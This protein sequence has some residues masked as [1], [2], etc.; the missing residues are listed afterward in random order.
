MTTPAGISFK[1]NSE[2]ESLANILYPVG[3]V[4]ISA[5]S[6]I[7]PASS[8]G[9]QWTRIT[10]AYLRGVANNS[11]NKRGGTNS[12][13][14]KYGV[15]WASYYGS[16]PA[17]DQNPTEC[18]LGLWDD[19]AGIWS[20]GQTHSLEALSGFVNT[21]LNTEARVRANCTHKGRTMTVT[22]SVQ[23]TFHGVAVWYRSA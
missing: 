6:D 22:K 17:Y 19:N 9:G 15:D 23:P 5:S 12:I 13:S 3:S 2:W 4:F 21:G 14:W 18:Y 16:M 8:I 7:S 11:V 1:I 20:A 10:D